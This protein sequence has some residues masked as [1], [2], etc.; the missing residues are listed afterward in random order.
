MIFHKNLNPK[1]KSQPMPIKSILIIL[2][3]ILSITDSTKSQSMDSQLLQE[4]EKLWTEHPKV[5]P[6]ILVVTEADLLNVKYP[7]FNKKS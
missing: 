7:T 4:L 6:E 1:I 5:A 3:S 2:L